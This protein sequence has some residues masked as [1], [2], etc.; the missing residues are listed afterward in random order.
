MIQVS[1]KTFQT[2]IAC[3]LTIV[4]DFQ[5][6]NKSGL[7]NHPI[8]SNISRLSNGVKQGGIISPLLFN[9][10]MDDLSMHLNSSGIEGFLGVA[11]KSN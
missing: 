10:Y 6:D 3:C 5:E 8:V 11:H 1:L 9:T 2:H 4:S 7:C